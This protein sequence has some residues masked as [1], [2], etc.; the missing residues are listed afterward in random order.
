MAEPMTPVSNLSGASAFV[1]DPGVLALGREIGWSAPR[2][3]GTRRGIYPD[4]NAPILEASRSETTTTPQLTHAAPQSAIPCP[5]GARRRGSAPFD[6]PTWGKV[7]AQTAPLVGAPA[8]FG[9]PII[10]VLGP[11]LL[12]A[13]LLI[14]PVALICTLLLVAALAA[15]LLAVCV[16]VIVSPYL[17]VRQLHALGAASAKPRARVDLFRKHR[18]SSGRPGSPQ[19]KGLS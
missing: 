15:G 19:P 1:T 8:F 6:R 12:L 10:F 4:A 5:S 18:V 2:S 16:A 3:L 7:F 14:G 17:L 11:W 13:L 9:P